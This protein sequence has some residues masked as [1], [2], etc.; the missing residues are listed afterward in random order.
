MHE[1]NNKVKQNLYKWNLVMGFLHLVQGIF[2]ILI[3]NSDRKFEFVWNLPTV[4]FL[5]PIVVGRQQRP[6]IE[7]ASEAAVTVNLSYMIAGFLF[8]SAIA[9]F[10]TIVPIVNKWYNHN[11]AQK[12]NLIRWYEYALSSSLMVVVIAALCNIKDFSIIFL[13]VVANASMNL[14]GAM[15]EKH[16]MALVSK[17]K[18]AKVDWTS[19]VYGCIAGIAPW[20]IMSVYFFTTLGRLGEVSGLPQQVKDVLATV[21][22]IFPALFVFF[23]LFAINMFLQYKKVGKWKDYLF[24][25]KA[26]IILSLT[27]KSFLAWFIWGGTL[28]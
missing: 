24:G 3:S 2:M 11:L 1:I 14:F 27:A 26:Y 13:L 21:K 18:D 19:F 8:L 20:V 9:H 12:M 10:I 22:F 15:M 4:R 17:D 5:E 7:Y 16:N 25:E 28:R 6:I 23:N